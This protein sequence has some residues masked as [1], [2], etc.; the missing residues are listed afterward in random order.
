M[1]AFF[2]PAPG[3]SDAQN[4]ISASQ[5]LDQDGLGYEDDGDHMSKFFS[6]GGSS[7]NDIQVNKRTILGD[8][9]L[10]EGAYEGKKTSRAEMHAKLMAEAEES[11]EDEGDDESGE[12]DMDG[13]EQEEGES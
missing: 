5:L 11:E 1:D 13:G 7:A 12:F 8:I 6:K 3:R 4:P 2:N 9:E 10:G